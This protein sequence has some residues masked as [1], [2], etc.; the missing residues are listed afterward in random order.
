MQ[1]GIEEGEVVQVV[2]TVAVAQCFDFT[3][4]GQLQGGATWTCKVYL[5]DLSVE[6][7]DFPHMWVASLQ[8][9]CPENRSLF[10]DSVL[11]GTIFQ[12]KM[13]SKSF[14]LIDTDTNRNNDRQ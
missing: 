3:S 12:K 7:K 9:H 14:S 6:R 10:R 5:H 13:L 8:F 11:N 4:N 1:K 2:C